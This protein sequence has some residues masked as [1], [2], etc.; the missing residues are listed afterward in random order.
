MASSP[1]RSGLTESSP[2]MADVVFQFPS[3]SVGSQTAKLIKTRGI[4]VTLT[5]VLAE[6]TGATPAHVSILVDSTLVHI[7][8]AS[9]R[10]DTL[11]VIVPHAKAS[12]KE[13]ANFV[14]N[15]VRLIKVRYKNLSTAFRKHQSALQEL[16]TN[17][18]LETIFSSLMT[19]NAGQSVPNLELLPELP[20]KSS[21]RFES[22]LPYCQWLNLPDEIR[23][24]IDDA[25]SQFESADFQD[26]SEEFYDL[27]REF[28][29]LGSCL[30]HKGSLLSSHLAKDDL[31]DVFLWCQ[32][33]C[34]LGGRNN[35]TPVHQ[36]VSWTEI[37][38]TRWVQ[39][40]VK[41][42]SIL[43]PTFSF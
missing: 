3:G 26:F 8:V 10:E 19:T 20:E 21:S 12:A 23:F 14:R 39:K 25:I 30:F 38:L 43:K 29:I 5:E 36:L 35:C 16:F 24:Q 15:L 42:I 18:A 28:H 27:P 6:V 41:P 37:H 13:V 1:C 9:E 17:F 7:G 2:D 11:I 31:I 32:N 4:L 33:K 40:G 22:L 34:I